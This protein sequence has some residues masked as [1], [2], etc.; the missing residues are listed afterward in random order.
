[1]SSTH[2]FGFRSEALPRGLHHRFGGISFGGLGEYTDRGQIRVHDSNRFIAD[3][4]AKVGPEMPIGRGEDKRS[5]EKNNSRVIIQYH[6]DTLDI[7]GPGNLSTKSD[8][9]LRGNINCI[10]SLG[11]E[12]LPD[13]SDSDIVSYTLH[14]RQRI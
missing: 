11:P 10:V 1:M 7:R 4:R 3:I 6:S 9:R 14:R 8:L 13:I 12:N 2:L 5:S